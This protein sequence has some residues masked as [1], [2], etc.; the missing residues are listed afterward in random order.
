MPK[1]T[2]EKAKQVSESANGASALDEDIYTCRLMGV[3]AKESKAGSV[4]WSWE[5]QVDDGPFKGRKLWDNTSLSDAAVWRLDKVFEAFGE[6]TNTDT[7]DLLGRLVDLQV[8]QQIIESGARA[9]EVGNSITRVFASSA[10]TAD[11]DLAF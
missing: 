9:G 3:E 4:Y 5:Y 11:E 10:P 7:D 8:E 2:E 6:P 1:L